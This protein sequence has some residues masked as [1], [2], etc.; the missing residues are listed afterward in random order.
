[1]GK[2]ED[3]GEKDDA[4]ERARGKLAKAQVKLH[5]AEA[6]YAQAMERGK[7]EVERARLRAAEWEANAR[8][9]VQ[10]RANAVARLEARL[11]ST[12][13]Q[14]TEQRRNGI[15]PQPVDSPEKA[16]EVLERQKAKARGDG[17]GESLVV[18]G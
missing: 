10:R 2:R 18:P 12:E 14:E 17:H 7:Q 4:V 9:R 16:A 8:E 6:K 5:A 1:M 3:K 11:I 15:A 13:A